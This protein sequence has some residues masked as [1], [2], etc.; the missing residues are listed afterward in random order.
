MEGDHPPDIQLG[1]QI[2]GCVVI[3]LETETLPIRVSASWL[4][5]RFSLS[6]QT[7]IDK[8]RI[9]NKGDENKHLYD[10]NEVIPILE[11]LNLLKNK[12]GRRRKN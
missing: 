5:E 10:P 4:M 11:N 1:D 6:R 7:I 2:G 12:S 8:L 3:R 9:F